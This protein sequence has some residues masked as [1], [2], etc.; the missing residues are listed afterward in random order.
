MNLQDLM[1]KSRAV[2]KRRV[3]PPEGF[4]PITLP[5]SQYRRGDAFEIR[6]IRF[7]KEIAAAMGF[8]GWGKPD[9]VP[10][11]PGRDGQE[12]VRR[13]LGHLTITTSKAYGLSPLEFLESMKPA[14]QFLNDPFPDGSSA[15]IRE[16]SIDTGERRI[17]MARRYSDLKEGAMISPMA[18]VNWESSG[19][20]G[21][22][23]RSPGEH[24]TACI[25]D[26]IMM[27]RYMPKWIIADMEACFVHHAFIFDVP[28]RVARES[29]LE[30]LRC[31][32][33][34]ISV[35]YGFLDVADFK[36]RWPGIAIDA[37]AKL[38]KMK[39]R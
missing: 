33:D 2:G 37:P 27:E 21:Y 35:W 34:I 36:T 22:G 20:T 16:V 9:A 24:K 11:E 19:G 1:K 14:A 4:G 7:Y 29:V 25:R 17:D 28:S 39:R 15:P 3:R 31:G 5:L 13:R 26:V 12:S 10:S 23:P 18:S 6:R 8:E 38:K 30:N 32:L